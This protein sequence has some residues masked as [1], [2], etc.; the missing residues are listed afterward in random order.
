MNRPA[1]SPAHP[2]THR[3]AGGRPTPKQAA[4][5]FALTGAGAMILV[6]TVGGFWLS[7]AHLAEVAGQHGLHS[8]AA[9]RWAWPA[10]LDAFIVAGE[11]LML[12]AGLRGITDGW[13]IALTATGSVGSIAL[14]VAGVNG[15]GH[16][17]HVAPLDYVVAAV[18]PA[19]ALL[20]FR[21]LMRQIHHLVD[22]PGQLKESIDVVAPE[23]ATVLPVAPAVSPSA[24]SDR[25][26]EP[27][28]EVPAGRSRGG[29]PAS[30]TV[31][32]LLEIGRIAVAESG[33]PTRGTVQRAIK[34][35]GHTVSS[36]RLTEV[37]AILR[38]EAEDGVASP[39]DG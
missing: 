16:T 13:A 37:M 34:D 19:A 23:P 33:N 10:T 2:S 11:L 18:P 14:N 29:R 30:A 9:R 6:L 27:R 21:V 38:S 5:R 4:E 20:A 7:Y 25:R 12:R 1:P 22:R 32:E 39:V 28:T 26:P 3:S 15:S 24:T 35:K 17:G 36:H 8:S 31:E